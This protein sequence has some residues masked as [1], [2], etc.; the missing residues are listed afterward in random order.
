M[1]TPIPSSI[2]AS[3]PNDP[4]VYDA[5][6]TRTNVA[7]ISANHESNVGS[8]S[9][10]QIDKSSESTYKQQGRTSSHATNPSRAGK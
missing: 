10:D 3:K 1:N 8:M 4:H 5:S 7:C 6:M 9:A 2:A